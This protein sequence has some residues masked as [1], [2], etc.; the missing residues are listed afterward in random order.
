MSNGESQ[1]SA[2]AEPRAADDTLRSQQ[3]KIYR[4]YLATMATLLVLLSIP[5][6]VTLVWFGVLTGAILLPEEMGVAQNDDTSVVAMPFD[7]RYW[8]ALKIP[9]IAK[10]QP[11]IVSI[12]SSRSMEIRNAMFA[13]YKFYNASLTAWTLDQEITMIDQITRVSRPRIIIV[14]LDYFMFTN[15]YADAM[16]RERTMIFGNDWRYRL[17]SCANLAR[18][19]WRR[20]AFIGELRE[21]WRLGN[22]PVKSGAVT[23]LGIDAIRGK[24]GFRFD[25]STLLPSGTYAQAPNQTAANEGLIRAVNGGPSID[26]RQ[27]QALERLAEVARKHGVTLVAIQL[28]ILKASV[29]VL[30]NDMSYHYYSGVWRE[31][32]SSEFRKKLDDLGIIILRPKPRSSERR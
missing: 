17:R 2:L 6:A 7:L 13:P 19:F 11:E 18:E 23:L 4:R 12:G 8:A 27:Y 28:P 30:D 1:R 10:E 24:T 22:V 29:D 14:S 5:P 25:G 20:P 26:H 3:R 16:A 15:R 21:D 31:F 32:E 9:R